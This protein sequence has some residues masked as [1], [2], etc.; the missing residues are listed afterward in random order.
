M[1]ICSKRCTATD[2]SMCVVPKRYACVNK[3]KNELIT[4]SRCK[5]AETIILRQNILFATRPQ[6]FSRLF[7]NF[8]P[9]SGDKPDKGGLSLMPVAE[10]WP[11]CLNIY[12]ISIVTIDRAIERRCMRA[13]R[14]VRAGS[15]SQKFVMF[16]ALRCRVMLF[17]VH[18]HM[19]VLQ[20]LTMGCVWISHSKMSQN[21]LTTAGRIHI[22]NKIYKLWFLIFR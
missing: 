12:A 17:V 13:L 1:H 22:F 16:G 20:V 3:E 19:V 7:S 2:G 11:Y 4:H 10:W 5:Q 9:L 6:G 8:P 15:N 18:K 21:W 14:A